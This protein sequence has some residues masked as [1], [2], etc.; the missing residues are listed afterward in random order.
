VFTERDGKF[1]G[2]A[3]LDAIAAAQERVADDKAVL[4]GVQVMLVLKTAKGL[5]IVGVTKERVD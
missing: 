4:A 5:R 2:E 1:V 3:A